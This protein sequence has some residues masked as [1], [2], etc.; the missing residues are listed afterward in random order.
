MQERCLRALPGQQFLDR[1]DLDAGKA[2]WFIG[3]M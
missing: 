2:C 3:Q 1:Q